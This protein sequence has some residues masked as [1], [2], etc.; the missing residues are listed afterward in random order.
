MSCP[1]LISPPDLLESPELAILAVLDA[2]LLQTTYALVAAHPEIV[3]L[4]TFE[5]R[6]DS[7]PDLWAADALHRELTTMQLAIARYRDALAALRA[8]RQFEE[9]NF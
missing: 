3:E 8:R 4:E 1:T 9:P 7:G 2:T 6:W 5:A